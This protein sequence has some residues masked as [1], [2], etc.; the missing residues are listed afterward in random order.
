MESSVF[1]Q[2]L[3]YAWKEPKA[4]C[5]SGPPE[6]TSLPGNRPLTLPQLMSP[7]AGDT[8]GLFWGQI[9]QAKS[10]VQEGGQG[11]LPSPSSWSCLRAGPSCRVR[12][13]KPKSQPHPDQQANLGHVSP[14]PALVPPTVE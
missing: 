1:H 3:P 2:E 6:D 10:L 8:V 11:V 9:L 5:L 14:V 4:P 7:H 12:I 13:K